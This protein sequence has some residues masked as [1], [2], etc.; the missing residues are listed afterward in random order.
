MNS[1]FR[2]VFNKARGALMV[3]NEITS[4]VQAKGTKTVV[5]TAAALMVA[6]V[7]Q[8]AEPSQL[9]ETPQAPEASVTTNYV[10]KTG[11]TAA[12]FV[13]LKQKAEAPNASAEAKQA[14]AK[15]KADM[16][17]GAFMYV[18]KDTKKLD[19]YTF[20][21]NSFEM[22]RGLV[23]VSN[24]AT[25]EV[26]NST[27]EGNTTA[28]GQINNYQGTLVVDKSV[29]KNNTARAN[30]GAVYATN[31]KTTITNSVFEGN[32]ATGAA[33]GGKG[34]AVAVSGG[35]LTLTNVD[36]TK[37]EAK[38]QGGALWLEKGAKVTAKNVN[39]VGN[40]ALDNNGG[41]INIVGA[42]DYTQDGGIISGNSAKK[43]G[44]AIAISNG[45][46]QATVAI[47]NAT[48]KNNTAGNGG[49]V[50]LENGTMTFTD[51]VFSGNTSRGWGGAL[52][53]KEGKVNLKVTEGKNLVYAGNKG[54]TNLDDIVMKNFGHAGDF[55]YLQGNQS[56]A[57]FD[58]GNNASLTIKDSILSQSIGDQTVSINKAGTG[59]LTFGDLKGFVGNLNVNAGKVVVEGGIGEFD[60]VSQ[61][62]A[63]DKTSVA[64]SATNVKVGAQGTLELGDVVVNRVVNGGAGTIFDVTDGG[65][66]TM[67][68][69]T[70]TSSEYKNRKEPA[71]AVANGPAQPNTNKF[72]GFA[73]VKGDTTIKNG[74]K[75]DKGATFDIESGV[76]TVSGTS[77]N[78]GKIT[79]KDNAG[80]DLAAGT[81]TNKGQ[82]GD[83]S[84]PTGEL[85][86]AAGATLNN[87][88]TIGVKDLVVDGTLTT[89]MF[90][91]MTEA[92][93]Q[94]VKFDSVT[95]NDGG[96]FVINNLPQ[97]D[98]AT[99]AVFNDGTVNL[100]GGHFYDKDKVFTGDI[101]T[102]KDATVNQN[103]G[104]YTYGKLTVNGKAN[105]NAGKLTAESLTVGANANASIGNETTVKGDVSIKGNASV[106]ETGT[107]TLNGEKVLASTEKQNLTN[108][109]TVVL[110]GLKGEY[111]KTDL[112]QIFTTPANNTGVID[113][114]NATIKNVGIKDGK[115]AY[116]DV[117]DLNGLTNEALK[118]AQV[119]GVDGALA[120]SFD[121]VALADKGE[122]NVADKTTLEL[123]G[124]GKLVAAADGKLAGATVTGTLA[125]TGDAAQIGDL[126]GTGTLVVKSGDLTV[127]KVELGKAIVAGDL[128][129]N[130]LTLTTGGTVTGN[131]LVTKLTKGTVFAG[132]TGT[133]VA[134]DDAALVAVGTLEKDAKLHAGHAGIIAV[135]TTDKAEVLNGLKRADVSA[136]GADEYQ[137]AVFVKADAKTPIVGHILADDADKASTNVSNV[138]V[139]SESL[140][141]IAGGD[142][143]GKTAVFGSDLTNNGDLMVL[144]ARKGEKLKLAATVTGNGSYLVEGDRI[145]TVKN[146]NGTLSFDIAKKENIGA[147]NGMIT[148]N[149]VYDYFNK[150]LNGTGTKSDQ[151]NSFLMSKDNGLTDAQVAAVANAGAMLGATAGMG[152]VT[153][154]ALNSFNDAI[155]ARTS[156]LTTRGEGVNLWVD[157]HAGRNKATELMDGAGYKSDLYAGVFGVDTTV[158]CGAVVGAALTFG[159]ADTDSE[160]ALI[161]TS[162]DSDFIGLS[163]YTSKALTDKVNF[164][165]NLGYMQG[166]N[167]VTVQGYGLGEF[168][169]DTTA[170]TLGARGEY[171]AYEGV[172][173]VIPHVGFRYTRLSTDSFEAA[174]ETSFD[175]QNI[176]QIPIGVSVAGNMDFAGWKV[177]LAA[178]LSIVPTFGD[179]DATMTLGLGSA[180][181]TKHDVQVVDSNPVQLGLGVDAQK[182]A[183]GFGVE[184]KL[185]AGSDDRLNNA[186][187]A[188][189]NYAF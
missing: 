169:A 129:V 93:A 173:N 163:L 105:L 77:V 107:L 80:L 51:T 158:S 143:T 14:F 136:L 26:A 13:E 41:A 157:V 15:A 146:D 50:Y 43:N 65:S 187:H 151:F 112:D 12:E 5:A 62:N 30:A 40:T 156:M 178:D 139:G 132:K 182:G 19:G 131:A 122:V 189:V 114:G 142:R 36:F 100:N 76:T 46:H 35:E 16:H 68:S 149:T 119:T 3:V 25:L 110:D 113:I 162:M 83:M 87:Q 111:S 134:M 2:V 17:L 20:K 106:T 49:A 84:S 79:L 45:N 177:V 103:G 101:T 130:E 115:I 42:S 160:N 81:M 154:D 98:G 166:K 165:A 69:L 171:L 184:W 118:K 102:G 137:S 104:D 27:F 57:N 55:M 185:G 11:L 28:F 67:N 82:L 117:K 120:G 167:D 21:N 9:T 8:A 95:L 175:D 39:Y 66:L 7:A 140:M 108:N 109:G 174:Y 90:D 44:G 18:D 147:L 48:F 91:K 6:G 180:I 70:V 153:M 145:L 133:T 127:N 183:W 161:G 85:T 138:T 71:Q 94:H 144:D 126:S 89:N 164:S 47:T 64:L 155:D 135:G 75:V 123:N 141:V 88:A 33:G 150:G 92:G 58:I 159:K 53:V 54:G 60:L 128:K 37:N 121:S 96:K 116:N 10:G 176:F 61:Q 170:W 172:V 179:K 72:V 31:G 97:K 22:K 78:E 99:Q 24:G 73:Q 29:F 38:L 23:K 86:I 188:R 59:T 32:K 56:A 181:A 63:N 34:G 125:T 186:F 124:T 168:S 52:Y 148:G 74:L 152:A 4:C 1:T